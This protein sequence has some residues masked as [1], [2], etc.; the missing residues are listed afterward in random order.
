[1]YLAIDIGGSK[2]LLAGLDGRGQVVQSLKFATNIDYDLFLNDLGT[3]L[4]VLSAS[5]YAA[6]CVAVP[7]LIDRELGIVRALG[8]LPWVDK[9]IREDLSKLLPDTNTKI[10]IEND[11]R[12]AGLGAA[13]PL[14][15][16]FTNILY[17]TISTGI[18]GALITRGKIVEPL[19]DM[20]VGKIPVYY[21]GTLQHWE[22]F[23]S[24]RAIVERYHKRA[25]EIN[26]K[27]T[28]DEIADAIG[29]GVAIA[30]ST[31]QPD[32][33]V[34]GGGVGQFADKFIPRVAEY[35][36]R[37][38]HPISI[39]PELITAEKPEEV[40]VYGCFELGRQHAEAN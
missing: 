21:E 27:T 35:M 31:I 40:V 18:G 6:C 23:A 7:G 9:P 12:L 26:D 1:M 38:M 36:D 24:G 13:Q 11:S 4:K 8:N 5:S 20:E 19:R 32:V 17:L 29:Y 14:K 34:F 15:E 33:I 2:T 28:W 22:N 16:A 3:H 37:I 10:I 25:S 30:S 39:R